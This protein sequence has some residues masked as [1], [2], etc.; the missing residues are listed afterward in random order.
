MKRACLLVALAACDRAKP[1]PPAPVQ[2]AEPPPA[3][4][5]AIDVAQGLA[6]PES[7]VF[8]RVDDVY[9]VSNING[10]PHTL[11][12]NGFISRLAP[13]GTVL[14][15]RWIDGASPDVTL[16]APRG[17][18][19]DRDTLYVVDQDALRRFDRRTGAP[20][21]ATPVPDPHVPNDVAVEKPGSVLVTETGIHL[22]P[23][24]PVPEGTAVVW[25]F[26]GDAAPERVAS[27]D[28][29]QGPNG[30][31]V[32]DD[33]PVIASFLG[34]DLYRL[35]DGRPV[36]IATLPGWQLDGLVEL[37]DGS[38]LVTSWTVRGI[39]HVR[40]DGSYVLAFHQSDLVSAASIE[41]DAGRHRL[42]VPLVLANLVRL[43]PYP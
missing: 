27:G 10:E 19:I 25:R 5:Q 33:G 13:D 38:F 20:L 30:I 11:D 17:L 22:A 9:L 35:V 6:G 2:V 37:P 28:A 40:P 23:T 7:I 18:A 1:P 14:V 31:V 24:G 16:N 34:H 29:L 4:P 15:E 12:D 8:D 41:Y 32:T 26:T 43:E 3:G 39:Y 21:G 36:P 42:L